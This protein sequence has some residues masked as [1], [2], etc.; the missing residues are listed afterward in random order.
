MYINEETGELIEGTP[1][2]AAR[3]LYEVMREQN[4]QSQQAWLYFN[5]LSKEKIDELCKHL[6]SDTRNF[7]IQLSI[8]DGNDLLLR[9][10][11]C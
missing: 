8:G 2:R 6:P 11:Y 10:G 7:H 3:V 4:Y 9:P 5:D 1:I